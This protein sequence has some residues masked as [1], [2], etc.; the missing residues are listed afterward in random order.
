M[1]VNLRTPISKLTFDAHCRGDPAF[2]G[3]TEIFARDLRQSFVRVLSDGLEELAL[4]SDVRSVRGSFPTIVALILEGTVEG[5]DQLLSHVSA[6]LDTTDDASIF[7]V[8]VRGDGGGIPVDLDEV[9]HPGGGFPVPFGS[10]PGP[11]GC[12]VNL[13]LEIL[14]R[15]A[16]DA[17]DLLLGL[18][19]LEVPINCEAVPNN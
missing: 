18:P 10:G 14:I 4:P 17:Y 7:V 3:V 2:D 11:S 8:D 19:Y 5:G 13:L 16:E 6:A 9:F 1:A 12:H 15:H